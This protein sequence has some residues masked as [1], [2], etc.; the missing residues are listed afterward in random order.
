M[1]QHNGMKADPVAEFSAEI[2]AA[3]DVERKRYV[4]DLD[5]ILADV[6][7]PPALGGNRLRPTIVGIIRQLVATGA[8]DSVWTK[9][10]KITLLK[11]TRAS[12]ASP[13]SYE[14]AEMRTHIASRLALLALERSDADEREPAEA[15]AHARAEAALQK[16]MGPTGEKSRAEKKL[17]DKAKKLASEESSAR[18]KLEQTRKLMVLKAE[19]TDETLDMLRP[20]PPPEPKLSY[21][22][23]MKPMAPPPVIQP[24]PARGGEGQTVGIR[25]GDPVDEFPD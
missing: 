8:L 23:R 19:V 3:L 20:D 21:A 7:I 15:D 17:N 12:A 18:T 5:K 22:E 11:Y 4:A 14:P 16:F 9:E 10:A 6:V 2:E 24:T 1:E 13:L 25:P